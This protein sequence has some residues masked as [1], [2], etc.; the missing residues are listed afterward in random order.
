MWMID[1]HREALRARELDS[2][3][4]DPRQGTLDLPRDVALKLFFPVVYLCQ[5]RSYHEK[6]APR[7]HFAELVKCGST[8]IASLLRARS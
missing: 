7:A 2:E 6:W 3:N 8:R 4:L 1:E 5:N